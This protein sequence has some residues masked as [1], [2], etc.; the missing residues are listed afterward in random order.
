MS[1]T[2][3]SWKVQLAER[4]NLG[5]L[6]DELLGPGRKLHRSCWNKSS[7]TSGDATPSLSFHPRTGAWV[8]WA[9]GEKGDLFTLYEKVQGQSFPVA[10]AMLLERYGIAGPG[11]SMKEK[12]KTLVPEMPRLE[13][14][15]FFNA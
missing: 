4:W 12:K 13:S 9:C 3:L 1:S 15:R 11:L 7:H 5:E 2:A 14:G 10:L 6:F 8:C